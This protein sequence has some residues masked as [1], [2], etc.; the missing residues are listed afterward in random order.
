M[1]HIPDTCDQFF[2]THS[3]QQDRSTAGVRRT[4]V[5]NVEEER[6]RGGRVDPASKVKRGG[7]G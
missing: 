2:V 5:V 6:D 7:T 3:C 1:L 4:E